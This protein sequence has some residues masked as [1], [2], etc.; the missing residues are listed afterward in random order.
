VKEVDLRGDSISQGVG[1]ARMQELGARSGAV[2]VC[3]M[4][5]YG[6]VLTTMGYSQA[7][8]M[9]LADVPSARIRLFIVYKLLIINLLRLSSTICTDSGESPP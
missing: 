9:Q 5:G 4:G 3:L 8:E 7:G 1:A 2:G 6:Q